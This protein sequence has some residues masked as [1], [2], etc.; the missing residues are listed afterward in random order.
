MLSRFA[1]I[2]Y[3]VFDLLPEK[4]AMKIKVLL[5]TI[6]RDYCFMRPPFPMCKNF[7]DGIPENI[8]EALSG[9]DK[10]SLQEVEEFLRRVRM[11]LLLEESGI[12]RDSFLVRRDFLE[13]QVI[14]IPPN[15]GTLRKARRKYKLSG[16][17]ES[18]IYQHGLSLLSAQIKEYISNKYFIDAGASDGSCSIPLMEYSPEKI[19]AFEPFPAAVASYCKNMQQHGFSTENYEICIKALGNQEGVLRY[20]PEEIKLDQNGNTQ[21]EITTLDN[22]FAQRQECKI[23]FLKADLEGFGLD[24]LKGGIETIKRT[25]PVLSL[26]CYHTPEELFGQYQ[27]LKKELSNYNFCYTSLPPGKGYELTLLAIPAEAEQ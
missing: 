11:D 26:A 25:R 27:F 22:F 8:A 15:F 1:E 12:H 2:C 16:N 6:F 24:M 9:I 4:A 10:A 21:V 14:T 23:G 19:I 3:P 5:Q 13:N 7:K 18:L 20:N 17:V